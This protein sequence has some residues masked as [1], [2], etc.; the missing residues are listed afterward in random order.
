MVME[1]RRCLLG[2]KPSHKPVASQYTNYTGEKFFSVNASFL[3][4]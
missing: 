4:N 2:L 3:L 1:K